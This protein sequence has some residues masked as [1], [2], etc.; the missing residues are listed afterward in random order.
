MPAYKYENKAGKQLWYASFHYKDW[1][2]EPKRKVKRGFKTKREALDYERAFLDHGHK[3]PTILFSSLVEEYIQDCRSRLKPTTMVNKESIIETKL[4][5]YFGKMKVCDINPI[6]VRKWQVIMMDAADDDGSYAPT[7][8]KTIQSQLSA[9]MNYAVKYY[10]LTV[11]PCVAAGSMGDSYAREMTIWSREQFEHMLSFESRSSFAI[12]F[13]ILFW[14]GIREGELLALTPADFLDNPQVMVINKNF[15]VVKGKELIL[16]PKNH[17]S[18]RN[19]PLHRQLY[20]DIQEYIAS[21]LIEP[22][23]R[24]FYFQKSGL[25]SEFRRA[26]KKAGMDPIRIH[27]LR[28]SHASMLIHMKLPITE[29]SKRLGHKSPQTTLRIYAHLYPGNDRNIADTLDQLLTENPESE[30]ES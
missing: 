24:I 15:A 21:M 22:N 18:I 25:L 9:I 11:N 10:N 6:K 5:P 20:E 23:E 19:V 3:D 1:R 12:A 30:D 14:T 7:Y 8:L 28:H 13:K 29:I 27:D 4:V 17:W 16:T 2:G 26:T